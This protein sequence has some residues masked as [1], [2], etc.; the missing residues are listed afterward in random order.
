MFYFNQTIYILFTGSW[1]LA[2]FYLRVGVLL[3]DFRLRIEVIYFLCVYELLLSCVAVRFRAMAVYSDL[4]PYLDDMTI[5]VSVR[6]RR[7]R[8]VFLPI[9]SGIYKSL[10]IMSCCRRRRESC[11]RVRLFHPAVIQ[12]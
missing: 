4:T 6:R 1:R 2:L 10:I 11:S 3:L 12:S 7:R 9:K 5:I 8:R